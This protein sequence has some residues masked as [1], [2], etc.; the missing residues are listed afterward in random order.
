MINSRQAIH[1]YFS[2]AACVIIL[3]ILLTGCNKENAPDCFQSAG[4]Q[5]TV[6]RHL[7]PFHIIELNDYIQVE[8]YDTSAYYIEI[9][10]PKNLIPDISTKVDDGK[11]IIANHNTCNVVRSFK[12]RIRVRIYAPE[13]P[14]IQNYGTGDISSINTLVSSFFKIE[15]H[16]A[17]GTIRLK[18]HV[19]S[20]LIATHTG[21][22]D[23]YLVGNCSKTQLFNQGLG[24]IDARNLISNQSFVNNSSIN[25]V[26]VNSNDYLYGAIYY[27]GNIYYTGNPNHIDRSIQGSGSI[28]SAN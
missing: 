15:N 8:L 21:V 18:L 2:I 17:A 16:H 22:S 9:T 12:H 20:C 5:Q 28:S 23:C 26:Y 19:D 13:F 24:V 4:T 27:S 7:S 25:D 1:S 11:L 14:N 3:F 10:A 6:T